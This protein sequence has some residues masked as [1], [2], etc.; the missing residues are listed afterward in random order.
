[1]TLPVIEPMKLFRVAEPSDHF[2]WIFELKHDGFRSLAYI[3]NGQC[4]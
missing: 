2:D 4:R 1:V 3:E